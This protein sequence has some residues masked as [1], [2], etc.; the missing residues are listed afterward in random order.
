MAKRAL[1]S[2]GLGLCTLVGLLGAP[3]IARAASTE[4]GPSADLGQEIAKLGPGDELVLQGGTYTLSAKLTITVKGTASAPI[5]I[6]AKDG[7]TPIITRDASQNVI[8]VDNTEY[9][10]LRGLEITQGSHGIRMT[11]SSFITVEDCHI[12]NTG[13]VGVSANVPGSKYEGLVIRGNDIHDTGG[14]GEGMYLGCNNDGCQMFDSLIEK[15]HVHDT[16]NGVS[17]G[18]G[19]EIKQGSYNNIVRDNVIHDT[20]YPCLI[21]YGTAGHAVNLLERNAV[22]NCGD[23]GIQAEADAIIRNNLILGAANDGIHDQ[24]Q[25]QQ[26]VKDLTIV[27]NTIINAGDG[28]RTDAVS[29][30]VIIANNAIYSQS[31]NA[32][33][34][35]GDTTK[36]TI[37]GNFGM[38]STQNVSGG[39]TAGGALATDFVDAAFGGTKL[40]VFPKAGSKL[41]GAGD[42]QYV[43]DDDFN[44][45]QRNGVPDVGAY[46]YDAAGNPGWPVGPGFKDI[47]GGAGAGGSSGAGGSATGGSS[48][49]GSAGSAAGG[50]SAGGSAAGGSSA[51]GSGGQA[52][53]K[54]GSSSDDGGCGCRTR[55]LGP[56][57][58]TTWLVL[59]GALGWT[60]RRRRRTH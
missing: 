20:N 21:I 24:L 14:T 6:R 31:G 2:M 28:I 39:F 60:V 17:Q 43:T 51:G 34:V 3:A 16:I 10:V 38:G 35:S 11:N 1:G 44:G 7:E 41:I 13:D 59:L 58:S 30:A 37:A 42:T 50:S 46:K 49:G 54:S 9:I 4:I 29:G 57:P 36:I 53:A 56:S 19:I 55:P 32:I 45:T 12:H 25:Q 22:W 26:S 18:D 33:R 8:N 40:N 52:G 5:T 48:A 27:H 47:T 23:Q 15:N